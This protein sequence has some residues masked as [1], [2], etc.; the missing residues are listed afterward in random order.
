MPV[1][2]TSTGPEQHPHAMILVFKP[3]LPPPGPACGTQ[4]RRQR[5]MDAPIGLI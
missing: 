2:L 1:A 5:A 4:H 3:V